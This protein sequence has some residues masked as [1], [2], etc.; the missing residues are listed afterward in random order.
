MKIFVLRLLAKLNDVTFGAADEEDGILFED[1]E[2]EEDEDEL[3][4]Y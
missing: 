2:S 1:V 3:E 4:A